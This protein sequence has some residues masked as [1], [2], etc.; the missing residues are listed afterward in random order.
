MDYPQHTNQWFALRVKSRHEQVVSFAVREKG[1]EVFLPLYPQ[2]AHWS[3]RVKTT[4]SP[5]FPGYLFCRLKAR[6]RFP[7]LTIPGTLHFVAN[8]KEL[9]PIGEGEIAALQIAV[10]AKL[11]AE[12][13]PFVATGQT[14]LLERGPLAG[15]QGLLVTT[16]KR[17]LVISLTTLQRS[18]A[19]DIKADW[20][21]VETQDTIRPQVATRGSGL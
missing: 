14:L 15:V 6:E 9:I 17:R 19:I 1:F 4:P 2:T 8:G 5:L 21:A 10:N 20:V 11:G 7:I 18:V 12:P 3:D 16:P 13:I